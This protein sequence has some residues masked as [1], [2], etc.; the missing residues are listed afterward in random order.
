MADNTVSTVDLFPFKCMDAIICSLRAKY[1]R[2]RNDAQ[3]N[4][5]GRHFLK[6]GSFE[7]EIIFKRTPHLIVTSSRPQVDRNGIII[8]C[9]YL[10]NYSEEKIWKRI[11][12]NLVYPPLGN[13]EQELY[14]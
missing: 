3:H 12:T 10:Q 14:T 11:L 9:F 5:G 7:L 4:Y 8:T 6:W 1:V 2:T 13:K